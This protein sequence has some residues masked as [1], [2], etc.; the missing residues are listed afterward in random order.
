MNVPSIARA[1]IIGYAIY[2]ISTDDNGSFTSSCLSNVVLS[3]GI[4]IILSGREFQVI[5]YMAES[6]KNTVSFVFRR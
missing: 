4:A 3:L 5:N 2:S 1:A 6:V